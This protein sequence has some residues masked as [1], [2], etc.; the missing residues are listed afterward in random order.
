MWRRR[1]WLLWTWRYFRALPLERDGHIRI[2]KMM[3]G[4]WLLSLTMQSKVWAKTE[5]CCRVR[6]WWSANLRERNDSV[7]KVLNKVFHHR[8]K[9]KTGCKK[10]LEFAAEANSTKTEK[11]LSVFPLDAQGE[12]VHQT[13]AS[14]HTDRVIV[15]LQAIFH[16]S[17]S[18]H[19]DKEMSKKDKTKEW[20]L[21]RWDI[22]RSWWFQYKKSF[23]PWHA[24]FNKLFTYW[25]VF[26]I[27]GHAHLSLRNTKKTH[28]RSL[29]RNL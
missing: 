9:L 4:C 17:C 21:L 5:V 25:N 6:M 19:I 20:I 14:P 26:T 3:E 8:K 1:W 23:V 7:L 16:F 18:K 10:N 29:Q 22:L 15:K 13:C 27:S 24:L 12:D 2:Q 28:R 11:N